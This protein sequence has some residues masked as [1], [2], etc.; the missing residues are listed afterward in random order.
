MKKT[1]LPVRSQSTTHDGERATIYPQ[2]AFAP[3]EP[4]DKISRGCV[5]RIVVAAVLLSVVT[6]VLWAAVGNG[7]G[8]SQ[9]GKRG[10]DEDGEIRK[11][12]EKCCSDAVVAGV[13]G[14]QF[15]IH[16]IQFVCAT[17]GSWV[18]FQV[19]RPS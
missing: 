4:R 3:D 6:T 9:E 1:D 5:T 14:G 18:L 19:S 17:K 10:N 16:L 12:H 15:G 13:L 8:S 11:H 2:K 7:A